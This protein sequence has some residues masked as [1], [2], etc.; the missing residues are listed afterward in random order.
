[1][2]RYD[3]RGDLAPRDVV[4]TAMVREAERT[5]TR[6]SCRSATWTRNGCAGGFRHRRSV[7]QGRAR[8][9]PRSA[10]RQPRGALHVRRG[11]TPT[12]RAA[13][14]FPGCS[15]QARWRA[16]A[17]TAR[18]ASRATRCSKGSSLAPALPPRCGFPSATRG[19]RPLI[20]APAAPPSVP[21][22][23]VIS[24]A[25]PRSHV[26]RRW[27]RPRRGHARPPSPETSMPRP[28]RWK[29][30]LDER[31]GDHGD[32]QAANMARVGAP[33]RPRRAPARG[34]PRRPSPRRL[35]RHR[36]CT[37]EDPRRRNPPIVGVRDR[38]IRRFVGAHGK[39]SR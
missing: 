12:F 22:S 34:K 29:W 21:G 30:R 5:G 2:P 31:G 19:L 24:A 36:R 9:R 7:P 13:P 6:C 38:Q 23:A 26:A 20:E 11:R 10:A 3:A 14:P 15:P 27:P 35:P 25:V 16:P 18:T 1:M 8:L 37:L 28:R 4:A 33:H 32:W 17:S 39:A